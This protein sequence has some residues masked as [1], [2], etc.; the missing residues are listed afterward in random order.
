MK[1]LINRAEKDLTNEIT[2]VF[3]LELRHSDKKIKGVLVTFNYL[4][5]EMQDYSI[6][7]ISLNSLTELLVLTESYKAIPNSLF[8][9]LWK[10]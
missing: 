2:K 9:Q 10:D 6:K 8:Y 3:T 4:N 1:L 5:K 7:D